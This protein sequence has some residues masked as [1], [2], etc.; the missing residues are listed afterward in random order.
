MAALTEPMS[1]LNFA[2][3]SREFKDIIFQFGEPGLE[4]NTGV[5]IPHVEPTKADMDV[6][7]V[8]LYSLQDNGAGAVFGPGLSAEGI[9]DFI[10]ARNRFENKNVKRMKDTDDLLA[11]MLAPTQL[12]RQSKIALDT[13]V[14]HNGFSASKLSKD[15]FALWRLIEEIHVVSSSRGKLQVLTSFLSLK[16]ASSHEEYVSEFNRLYA[17]MLSNFESVTHRGFISI[18]DLSRSVYLKGVDQTFFD[19]QINRALEE[20]LVVAMSCGELQELFQQSNL[21]RG[22]LPVSTSYSGQ[23]LAS[24]ISSSPDHSRSPLGPYVPGSGFCEYCWGKGF[25]QMRNRHSKSACVYMKRA[26]SKKVEREAMS[27]GSKALATSSAMSGTVTRPALSDSAIVLGYEKFFS[28]YM[29]AKG[30]LAGSEEVVSLSSST[31]SDVT[32]DFCAVVDDMT[33]LDSSLSAYVGDCGDVQFD[34]GAALKLLA[35]FLSS[36]RVVPTLLDSLVALVA[37]DSGSFWYDNAA[38]VSIVRD[39]SLLS[40][41]APLE[42]TFSIGGLNSGIVATHSGYL[43]FLPREL[44]LAYFSKDSTVNLVSLGYLQQEGGSYCSRGRDALDVFDAQGVLLD[45]TVM[46]SNRLS[47]VSAALVR[48]GISQPVRSASGCSA[49]SDIPSALPAPATIHVNAEQRARLNRVEE[50]H[51]GVG[52]HVNDDALAEALH[53]GA[54]AWSHTSA[55]DVRLNR[56][57]R[58]PCPQCVQGKMHNK[59]MPPSM[60]PPAEYVGAV[61]CGDINELPCKSVG[62]NLVSLRTVDEFS[63]NLAET[64]CTGT[65]ALELFTGLMKLVNDSYRVHGHRVKHFVFDADPRLNPVVG[66]LAAV[67]PHSILLTFCDPG[68]HQR[69]MERMIG[70]ADERKRAVVAGLSYI[71]PQKYDIYVNK[72]I[73]DCQNG[74]PNSRSRPSTPEILVTGQRRVPHYEHPGLSFGSICMVQEHKDKRRSQALVNGRTLKSE[75]VAELGIMLGYCSDIPGDFNFLLS[76]SRIVPR[77]VLSCVQVFPPDG[78]AG[79]VWKRNVVH[80]AEL[81][82][83]SV[84]PSGELSESVEVPVFSENVVS[85][86]EPIF[87]SLPT[88]V[89][90]DVSD[91]EP[92]MTSA[93]GIIIPAPMFSDPSPSQLYPPSFP[94]PVP[95][96]EIPF[97]VASVSSPVKP[98]RRPVPPVVVLTP[99]KTRAAKLPP[100]FWEGSTKSGSANVASCDWTLVSQK[101]RPYVAASSSI[102]ALSYASVAAPPLPPVEVVPIPSRVPV[103]RSRTFTGAP[104]LVRTGS[105]SLLHSEVADGLIL[106]AAIAEVSGHAEAFVSAPLGVSVLSSPPSLSDQIVASRKALIDVETS[107]FDTRQVGE[108]GIE[109]FESDTSFEAS[110]DAMAVRDAN[111]FA[112]F[113]SWVD[114]PPASVMALAAAVAAN[115][116]VPSTLL[117]PISSTKCR[118]IP[119]AAALRSVSLERLRKVTAVEVDKQQ[120]LGCLATKFYNSLSDLPPGSGTVRAHCLYRIK[121]D[122]RETMRIAAMGNQLPIVPGVSNYASVT[123]DSDK[124]FVLAMMQAHAEFYNV[125]LNISSFDV[126]GGFLHIKRTSSVRLFLFLPLNLPHPLAGKYVEILG[127]LY[128]LRESN[129]LFMDELKRVVLSAGFHDCSISPMTFIACDPVDPVKR[130]TVSLHVD[131]ALSLDTDSMLTD[132]LLAVVEKRFGPLTQ[133]RNVTSVVFAGI[134]IVQRA[135]GAVSTNQDAYI[136]RSAREVGVAHLPPVTLPC[137]A[138]FFHA[139]VSEEDCHSVDPITYQSLTGKLIQVLK[140]RDEVR[141]FVSH[142]CSRNACPTEGDYAKALHLLRYL[143]STPGIGRVYKASAPVLYAHADAAFGF[144]ENGC[145]SGAYFLSVGHDNAPF[146]S[147]AQSQVDVAPCQ[148]SSE[149]MCASGSCKSIVHYRQFALE[150]GFPQVSSTPLALDNKTSID[151]SRAP[152]ITKKSKHIPVYYHYIRQLVEREVIDPVYV[153]SSNMRADILTKILPKNKFLCQRDMLFN[154]SALPDY[155]GLGKC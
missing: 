138:D 111:A 32:G 59:S 2:R 123:S 23:A 1:K 89:L 75:P 96:P 86:S 104:R 107:S 63:G 45:S 90:S 131:D 135:N 101:S 117:Q 22:G 4:I 50:L 46:A 18:D 68:A 15:T 12:S 127:A 39:I 119:I 10:A 97:E 136:S 141:P 6:N 110:L 53:N 44:A 153:S 132:R 130:C 33:L 73:A 118:E 93:A 60:S 124:M 43:S 72:W 14:G 24:A 84:F 109:D 105:I 94:L 152:E 151:L 26:L 3:T 13:K 92:R 64:P 28:D 150:L 78:F 40:G 88:P 30:R 17:D 154:L 122:D 155:T 81:A 67:E 133:H 20:P 16:Q 144:H 55:S 76:N 52:A 65:S 61:V 34:F 27:G 8:R 148:M 116:R 80:R 87:Q 128:G 57:L 54:F 95:S 69:R 41:A 145:S 143:H 7:G 125:P 29:G 102:S 66:M 77:R 99:R 106:Q 126:V 19:R 9:S 115:A 112:A 70:S 121:T 42:K 36:S 56:R 37:R 62:G 25:N 51:Q 113:V 120:R 100:G 140:T 103:P 5:R 31:N 139:S 49:S 74:L 98:A 85:V 149:Y 21:E 48:N 146:H 35:T 38:T 11:Y 71:V 58:G 47:P 142:S 129:R 108:F 83:P 114:S 82:V 147:K 134:E 137:Q 79:H 91:P